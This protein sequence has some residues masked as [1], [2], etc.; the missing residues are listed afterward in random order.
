M[1]GVHGVRVHSNARKKEH[2]KAEKRAISG[3]LSG[4]EVEKVTLE[5][6]KL[7]DQAKGDLFESVGKKVH[8][9]T[10]DILAKRVEVQMRKKLLETQTSFKVVE[11]EEVQACFDQFFGPLLFDCAKSYASDCK[12]RPILA[13]LI[14]PQQ[15]MQ[16]V[17]A[18]SITAMGP[19]VEKIRAISPQYVAEVK[20][21]MHEKKEAKELM[22]ELAIGL[23]TFTRKDLEELQA[24]LLGNTEKKTSHKMAFSSED[25]LIKAEALIGASQEANERVRQVVVEQLKI[26]IEERLEKISEPQGKKEEAPL[27]TKKA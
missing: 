17:K 2:T 10:L 8:D 21:K 27:S 16:I 3:K 5:K 24:H 11:D 26:I 20:E 18:Q 12:S 19:F 9:I 1:P 22:C 4:H 25:N 23:D 7:I 6:M 15:H 14:S 13:A